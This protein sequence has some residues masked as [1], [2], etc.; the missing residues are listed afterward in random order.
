MSPG[1]IAYS[2]VG[3][4][5]LLTW[6]SS[7]RQN[8]ALGYFSLACLSKNS[9]MPNGRKRNHSVSILFTLFSTRSEANHFYSRDDVGI[10]CS[11]LPY[12]PHEP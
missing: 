8:A 12:I 2:A 11:K 9:S 1:K 7:K 4:V 5:G 3:L 6:P 10:S